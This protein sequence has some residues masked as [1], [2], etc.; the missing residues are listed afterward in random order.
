MNVSRLCLSD[1][2]MKHI[3]SSR[4]GM[5]QKGVSIA[6]QFSFFFFFDLSKMTP[7][8]PKELKCIFL[9]TLFSSAGGY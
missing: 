7:H 1:K 8:L 9:L 4:L 3:L 6:E 5:L 2:L